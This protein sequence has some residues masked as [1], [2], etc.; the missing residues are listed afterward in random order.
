VLLFVTKTTTAGSREPSGRQRLTVTGGR[1]KR[2]RGIRYGFA[3]LVVLA[4]VLTWGV[5]S[6]S[7]HARLVEA[8]QDKNSVE[9][10]RLLRQ[11][12]DPNF[13]F[14]TDPPKRFWPRFLGRLGV[15]VYEGFRVSLLVAA[16]SHRDHASASA[17]LEAGADPNVHFGG[18]NTP[19]LCIAVGNADAH[20]AVV[21]LMLDKGADIEASDGYGST[22]LIEAANANRLDLVKLLLARGADPKAV[23]GHYGPHTALT[24][25]INKGNA[26]MARLLIAAGADI[27]LKSR[28][29]QSLIKLA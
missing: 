25:A 6:R 9:V 4:T 19:A 22:A 3:A 23:V 14:P 15:P 20:G 27:T 13:T 8:V 1:P 10:A 21:R 11:G 7:K 28:G 5:V 26:E 2:G 29:G 17:L 16:L 12:A 24:A 18:F